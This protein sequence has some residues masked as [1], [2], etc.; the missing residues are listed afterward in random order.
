M[1]GYEG[2]SK[3]ELLALIGGLENQTKSYAERVQK[4]VNENTELRKKELLLTK[5]GMQLLYDELWEEFY[6]YGTSCD[7]EAEN[8]ENKARQTYAVNALNRMALEMGLK[9]KSEADRTESSKVASAFRTLSQNE[10]QMS[11]IYRE[12]DRKALPPGIRL[13]HTPTKTFVEAP[14]AKHRYTS[15]NLITAWRKLERVLGA[16]P[17]HVPQVIA[18]SPYTV[19]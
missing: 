11:Y 17:S 4:L 7:P 1:S 19:I 8:P 5:L 18:S 9:V 12:E 15:E 6:F 14:P 2:Y 13:I 16:Q 10:V 3:Q